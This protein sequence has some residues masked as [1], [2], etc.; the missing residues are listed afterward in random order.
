MK[1]KIAAILT[2]ALLTTTLFSGCGSQ[3]ESN[4]GS[5]DKNGTTG[6]Q[7]FVFSKLFEN[8][9]IIYQCGYGERGHF[10]G[11]EE[12]MDRIR[13]CRADGTFYSIE[14]GGKLGELA[15]KDDEEIIQKAIEHPYTRGTYKLGIITDDTGN[16]TATESILV[17]ATYSDISEESQE[18]GWIGY[19]GGIGEIGNFV[20]HIEVYDSS[21][22]MFQKPGDYDSTKIQLIRDTEET[23]DKTIV[24]DAVGTDGIVVDKKSEEAFE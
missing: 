10:E 11:K 3:A 12:S 18:D 20:G 15:Q 17:Q 14:K 16:S 8:D 19:V 24:F 2:I 7:E 1:R 5:S 13:I 23:K 22:M 6:S 21:Y 9:V 4:S